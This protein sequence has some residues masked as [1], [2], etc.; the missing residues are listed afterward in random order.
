MWNAIA[1]SLPKSLPQ[2]NIVT[3]AYFGSDSL[4]LGVRMHQFMSAARGTGDIP[5]RPSVT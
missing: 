4:Q 2:R 1:I 5:H 3:S